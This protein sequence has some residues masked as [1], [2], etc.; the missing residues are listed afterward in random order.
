MLTP[1]NLTV[2]YKT[3]P[4]GM[5]EVRPRFAYN[6]DGDTCFQTERR[7][8]V[9][10]DAGTVVWDTEWEETSGTIQIE[11]QGIPLK[12]FTRYN[13]QVRVKDE[14]KKVSKWGKGFFETGF[15][16]GNWTGTWLCS[17]VDNST[18]VMRPIR[19][20]R[21]DFTPKGKIKSARLYAT[22]LGF[23][24]AFLNG[25]EVD[26]VYFTPGWTDYYKRV[27]YQAYDITKMLKA[28]KNNALCFL[29]A[30]GWYRGTIAT[31]WNMGKP[32]YDMLDSMIRAEL[33]ITYQDGSKEV[34]G[35]D[36]TFLSVDMK[37]RGS[38]YIR[39]SDIYMGENFVSDRLDSNWM[40]PEEP[41]KKYVWLDPA[42]NLTSGW[43]GGE[44]HETHTADSLPI[45]WTS[46]AMVRIV[47]DVE[48]VS[49][50][51]R[52]NGSWIV[53]FGQNLVGHE[54]IIL[55]N[56]EAGTHITIRHG[57]MLQ[58]NGALYTDN[59]RMA[60]A[61]T[62]FRAQADKKLE[63]YEPRFTFYGFRYLEITGWPGKL[64][65]K[66]VIARVIHSDL[67][68]TGTFQCSDKLVNQLYSNIIWGQKCNFVDVPTDCPQRDERLGWTGDT[69]VF[70]NVATYNM[71]A[72]EFYTKWI[73]DLN[74]CQHENG[75]Y[76]DFA[77]QPYMT[78]SEATSGWGDAGVICP[79]IM[80]EK[81]A[82]TRL[83]EKYFD[84]ICRWLDY[85]V[86]RAGGKFLVENSSY[87]DWLN[88]DAHTP[89]E[90]IST[91]YYAGMS[92]IAAKMAQ[93]LGREQDALERLRFY[94]AAADAFAE[95]Y[96]NKKGELTVRTQ[97]AALL[98]LSFG[99]V[100]GEYIQK[101]VDFLV[102]DIK[103]TRKLHLSTG[104]LGTPLLLKVLTQ[105]GHIDLAY[106]LLLQT[107]Y[108]S[109]LY[110][111]TQGATTM[112]ERWNTWTKEDG[113]GDVGMNSFNHYAYGAV[114]EWF[115]E[116]ICGINCVSE[117]ECTAGFQAILLAPQ[118]GKR[119]T[120]ASATY[121]SIS[122]EIKS[123]WKRTKTHF[124]WEFTVPRN[125]LAE[126]VCPFGKTLPATEGIEEHEDGIMIAQPGS[127][128][129]VLPL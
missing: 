22:A 46:G 35:S 59:L 101:T 39:Y 57:E 27:Q 88:I 24:S 17:S 95:K 58:A 68:Q 54:R 100:P 76:P 60:L 16:G 112:W 129:I 83:M 50:T 90:V 108:P 64:T 53:D 14:E 30:D 97:T 128:K 93:I 72:P 6:L 124:I 61:T 85:Q 40:R 31:H 99:C 11:Y 127:Y 23:Y 103:I 81:Y 45:V 55:R 102:K 21:K 104:F 20:F 109:W 8:K 25:M 82:D 78:R 86:K 51:Q 105:H 37:D 13:W 96:F 119:L 117:C 87:G 36:K 41:Y 3:N 28:E 38:S 29:F 113:F 19:C 44:S 43:Y 75:A 111:V 92:L 66:D 126:V 125:T 73:D 121:K 7:I 10:D 77:P 9:T 74:S 26:E 48:A 115:Y 4:I 52:K 1:Y 70:C 98:A 15:L 110:P 84:N 69:Q 91:T 63:I 107:T 116:T 94:Q 2:E 32:T 34:I 89:H 122:G 118:P 18:E 12:P 79:W 106:D 80:F 62:T 47:Q 65:E 5:D 67:P 71:Y 42:S 114:G 56:L 120:E 123:A 33:H 49:I